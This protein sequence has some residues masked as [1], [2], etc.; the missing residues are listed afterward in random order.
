MKTTVLYIAGWGRS[1]STILANSLNE[2][3]GYFHIGEFC[4]VWENAVL[5]DYPCGC[6]TPVRECPYWS[7]VFRKAL[8]RFPSPADARHMISLR[9]ETPS[10]ADILLR[11]AHTRKPF[12]LSEYRKR[13]GDLY[14]A[15]AATADA[16][17][18]IDSSK[19]P[20]HLFLLSTIESLNVHVLHLVRDPRA[21]AYSWMRKRLRS[22]V[23]GGRSVEMEQFSPVTN[24]RKWTICNLTI[25]SMH[26]R[27]AGYARLRYED[28]VQDPALA[29]ESLRGP[30]HLPDRASPFGNN[31]RIV[32]TGNHTV[33]GNP[34]RTTLGEIEIRP[35]LE[36]TEQMS[37]WDQARASVFSWPL[38]WHYGYPLLGSSLAVPP[39]R[40]TERAVPHGFPPSAT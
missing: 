34:K 27:F 9:R 18:I 25:Q 8:G 33:W 10:N 2:L 28:F 5:N 6:G 14:A 15:M 29:V 17:V 38:M 39:Q 20:Y 37:R 3:E 24:S 16:R 12:A 32:L 7:A 35:D 22:D 23:G 21:T 1:G 40:P 19:N 11:R 26:D 31:R 36:W 13:I 30:L 4:H